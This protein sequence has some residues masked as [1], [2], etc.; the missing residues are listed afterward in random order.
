MRK[1]ALVAALLLALV[2]CSSS[3]DPEQCDF[4]KS[5]SAGYMSSQGWVPSDVDQ[6]VQ[7]YCG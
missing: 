4:Y 6:A 5:L 2:G 7:E 3:Y 1:I